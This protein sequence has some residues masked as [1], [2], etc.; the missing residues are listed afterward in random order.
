MQESA[1]YS[2][3]VRSSAGKDTCTHE[4]LSVTPPKAPSITLTHSETHSL[5]LSIH[6]SSDGGSPILGKCI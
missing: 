3:H 5:N 2:C 1:N 6:S 4:L